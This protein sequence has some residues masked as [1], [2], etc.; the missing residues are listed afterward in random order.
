MD[1][2]MYLILARC[3]HLGQRCRFEINVM[4]IVGFAEGSLNIAE[5]L[6]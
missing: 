4:L 2:S 5:V 1:G 6:D 3:C